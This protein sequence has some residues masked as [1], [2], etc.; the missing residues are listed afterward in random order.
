MLY[1]FGAPDDIVHAFPSVFFVAILLS[2]AL[3]L[4]TLWRANSDLIATT[5]SPSRRGNTHLHL[6]EKGIETTHSLYTSCIKWPS[7]VEL[8][9]LDSATILMLGPHQFL[10]LDHTALKGIT[11][12]ELHAAI[13][14]WRDHA[15][16]NAPAQ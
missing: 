3:V 15:A 11:V 4:P 13:A 9:A 16:Q 14:Q 8:L 1:F 2:I 12:E 6:S 5:Q 7:I 10:P